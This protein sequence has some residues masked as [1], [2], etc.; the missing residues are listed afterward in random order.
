MDIMMMYVTAPAAA[1]RER[2]YAVSRSIIPRH[3]SDACMSPKLRDAIRKGQSISLCLYDD[4]TSAPVTNDST[5]QPA[6]GHAFC[7][8]LWAVLGKRQCS[9]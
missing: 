7:I 1:M 6:N 9:S 8:K 3:K 5:E 2:R 4:H